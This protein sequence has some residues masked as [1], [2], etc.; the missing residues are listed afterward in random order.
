[1]VGKKPYVVIIL[2]NYN[3]TDDTHECIDSLL[4]INYT[5]YS[6]VVVDNNSRVDQLNQLKTDTFINENATVIYSAE[7]NGFS[8]GNNIGIKLAKDKGADYVLLLNNDTIVTPD[9][10]ELLIDCALK[11][12]KSIVTGSIKYYSDMSQYW[13]AGGDY[14][15]HSGV[16][17]MNY[18][19]DENNSDEVKVTFATGCLMLIPMNCINM[20]GMLSDDF[21][22]YS[23]DTEY[24]LRLIKNGCEI[25]WKPSSLIYHK[26]N[27]SIG[28]NS[29]LQQYYLTRNDLIIARDYSLNFR[30]SI[31]RIRYYCFKRIIKRDYQIRPVL[32]AF[33]DFKK[34]ITGRSSKY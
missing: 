25:Y 1:M 27:A 3:G 26:V 6:I 16:T 19:I 10:L 8:E 29:P 17:S 2:V 5:N 34:G 32:D 15:F 12:D 7:N 21:F 24:C 11:H 4:R 28:K 22:L 31:C 14:D 9:F 33:K 18:H 23:E 13:Y 20:Y 30:K